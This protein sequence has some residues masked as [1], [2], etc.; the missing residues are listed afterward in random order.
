MKPRKPNMDAVR[1]KKFTEALQGLSHL[2]NDSLVRKIDSKKFSLDGNSVFHYRPDKLAAQEYKRCLSLFERR[3]PH[4]AGLPTMQAAVTMQMGMVNLVN[5]IM[6]KEMK[7]KD[8][9]E[10]LAVNIVRDLFDIPEHVQLLPEL[11]M[12]FDNVDEQDDSPEPV[13]SL[14]PEE[15][16]KMR[17]EIQKRI[18]LNGLV[19]GSAMHIWKSAHYI[20]SEKIGEIDSLLMQLYDVYTAAIGWGMW[21]MSPEMAL[22][23]IE[24]Q[25][26]TQGKNELKFEE[27]GEAECNIECS[28]INFPVLLHEVTKGAMDYLICHGIPQEFTEEELTYYYAKADAYENEYWHYL[29]SPSL[30][31]SFV[32]A[33]D[34]STQELPL[35]IARL[36]KLSYQELSSVMTSC[37]DGTEEGRVKLKEFKIV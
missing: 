31:V 11:N 21:Q 2:P 29:L 34:L 24:E 8:S 7:H 19:H 15:Q 6:V 4:A 33:A 32:E 26:L 37:I 16:R 23:S 30:W 3:M 18:I 25:G 10:H 28:G 14:S 17:E 27:A 36:T 22:A 1:E 12:G 9:L 20:I 5:S 13:L 35:A